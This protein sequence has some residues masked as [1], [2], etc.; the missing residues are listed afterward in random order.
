MVRRPS[1]LNMP[2]GGA[3]YHMSMSSSTS[4]R[5]RYLYDMSA[6]LHIQHH[7]SKVAARHLRGETIVKF[8]VYTH[9]PLP[10]LADPSVRRTLPIPPHWHPSLPPPEAAQRSSDT[11]YPCDC[12]IDA[13]SAH[14]QYSCHRGKRT[15]TNRLLN[16]H[17]PRAYNGL[18]SVL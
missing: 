10:P 12:S 17:I 18:R 7:H 13:S 6:H 3:R 2:A 8:S 4:K 9:P 11:L 15:C 1:C 14:S 16:N 5:Q